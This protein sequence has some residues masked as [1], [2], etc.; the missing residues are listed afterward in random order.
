MHIGKFM[1]RITESLRHKGER[2]LTHEYFGSTKEEAEQKARERFGPDAT[3]TFI[4]E[5]T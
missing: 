1:F 2:T 5:T 4:K 3:Y